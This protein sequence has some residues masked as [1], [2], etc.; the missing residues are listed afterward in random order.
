[1]KS[2]TEENINEAIDWLQETG[3]AI[4]DFAVEQA[5]LYCQEVINWNIA[6]GAGG[7]LL[8]FIGLIC[9][10]ASRYC[11]KKTDGE[12]GYFAAMIITFVA[13]LLLIIIPC[14][15]MVPKGVKAIT[16]PRVLILEHV[17]GL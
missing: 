17:R 9:F 2:E 1:M 11:C 12:D 6:I 14:V 7:L 15:E 16:S 8:V 3:G 10:V 4:Q 5:P 13:G